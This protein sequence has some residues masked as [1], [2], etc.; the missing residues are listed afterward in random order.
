MHSIRVDPGLRKLRKNVVFVDFAHLRIHRRCLVRSIHSD[1]CVHENRKLFDG[2]RVLHR[3][4][5][6]IIVILVVVNGARKNPHQ[7]SVSE[8]FVQEKSDLLNTLCARSR[9]GKVLNKNPKC[10]QLNRLHGTLLNH[11]KC[12]RILSKSNSRTARVVQ[13]LQVVSLV[14]GIHARGFLNT[15]LRSRWLIHSLLRS[16]R[17]RIDYGPCTSDQEQT[18]VWIIRND[19]DEGGFRFLERRLFRENVPFHFSEVGGFFFCIFLVP[20]NSNE[21]IEFEN[22]LDGSAPLQ[23]KVVA[24]WQRKLHDKSQQQSVSVRIRH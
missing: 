22:M 11:R 21:A 9:I 18:F 6:M 7:R 17:C 19:R 8:L 2:F 15:G 5:G 12:L 10:I 13:Y 4:I 14:H 20:M 16:C 3:Q 24:R 1:E 23:S